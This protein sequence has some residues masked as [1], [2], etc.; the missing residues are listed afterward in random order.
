[1]REETRRGHLDD[2]ELVVVVRPLDA[3]AQLR[4]ESVHPLERVTVRREGRLPQRRRPRVRRATVTRAQLD[5][6]A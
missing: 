4:V 1:M 2:E 6:L 5:E 3:M